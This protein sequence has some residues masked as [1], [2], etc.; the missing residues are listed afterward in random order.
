MPL[1]P[2]S[3]TLQLAEII[4]HAVPQARPRPGQHAI[5]PATRSFQALRIRVNDELGEVARALEDAA[6][7]LAPGGR[8]V[9]VSFHSLEDRIVKHFMLKA[10]GQT[11]SPSR[12]DPRGLDMRGPA[13]FR[14]ITR[15]A[16]RP[17]AAETSR[18]PRARSARLRAVEKLAIPRSLPQ[19]AAPHASPQD[20]APHASPQDAALEAPTSDDASHPA[21]ARS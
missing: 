4:R 13:E 20:A 7:L 15:R 8:L 19:D 11:P 14:L 2:I 16:A 21:E 9:V 3:S 18:N 1:A 12:H 5:H 6:R 17:G 10:S